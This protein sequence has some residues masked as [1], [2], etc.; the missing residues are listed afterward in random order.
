[1][2]LGPQSLDSTA[3]HVGF[4]DWTP[5]A[6]SAASC[7][8]PLSRSAHDGRMQANRRLLFWLRVPYAVDVALVVIGVILL[9]TGRDV[10][11]WVLIFAGVRAVIG[12]FA[13][14]VLAP[15][16]IAQRSG[17]PRE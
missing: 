13:L 1:M 14:L 11:W 9:L 15:R 4:E 3:L 5:L 7:R 10:G 12:T 6:S 17:T 16:I 8:G 2:R